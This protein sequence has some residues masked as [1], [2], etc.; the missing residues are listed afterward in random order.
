V[1]VDLHKK[2][3]WH[4]IWEGNPAIIR[5]PVRWNGYHSIQSGPNCRPY[6]VYP[7][8]AESG[9]TFNTDFKCRDNIAK[10]YLTPEELGI[11]LAMQET[12]GEYVLI[13]P[14][15]KHANMRWP[16]THWHAL[17]ASLPDVK[18]VQH[19]HKESASTRVVAPNVSFVHADWRQAC[20][21]IQSSKVY[22]RGESGLLHA[23]AALGKPTIALWG[24]CMDWDVMGGYPKQIGV[25]VTPPFCGK[26]QPC[27]HCREIMASISVES[28]LQALREIGVS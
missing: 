9:W 21:L 5:P 28:V 11:G 8:T 16:L 7:F 25:G 27:E 6:I 17:M 15:S 13:E 26:Y 12:L 4:P 10:I 18:F 20:G 23:A 1:I 24:G 3:R 19:V 14:W 22:I 2:P